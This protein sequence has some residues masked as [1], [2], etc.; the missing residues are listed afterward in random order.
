MDFEW[1][2]DKARTNEAKH[3]VSFPEAASVFGDPLAVT[4]DD[5][6]HS[7]DE[8][9]YLTIGLSA[10]G[11][12]LIV[13]HTDRGAATRIISARVASRGER[14]GYEDGDYPRA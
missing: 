14:K 10:T 2:E 12:V 13:S 1:D 9:R 3:G 6:L 11:R 7:A 4:F 5:P 8:D